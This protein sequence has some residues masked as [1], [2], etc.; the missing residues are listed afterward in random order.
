MKKYG[1]LKQLW[2]Q[3]YINGKCKRPEGECPRPHISA[4]AKKILQDKIQ[5]NIAEGKHRQ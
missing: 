2:C 5:K 4:E 1:G 3:A